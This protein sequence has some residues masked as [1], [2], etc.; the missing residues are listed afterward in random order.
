[1]S[2]YN[3]LMVRADIASGKATIR[4][5]GVLYMV[6]MANRHARG[7]LQ[8]F[9]DINTAIMDYR[10]PNGSASERSLS[11]EPVKKV[12]WDLYEAVTRAVSGETA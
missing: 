1:M 6:A 8:D 2:D 9:A 3:L 11:L 5:L 4:S 12:A 10:C 7:N